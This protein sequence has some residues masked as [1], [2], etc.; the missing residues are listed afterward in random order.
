MQ[1]TDN[2]VPPCPL[3]RLDY[4]SFTTPPSPATRHFP[5]PQP[6]LPPTT[7]REVAG[8]AALTAA[9]A[10]LV[11]HTSD[12]QQQHNRPFALGRPPG[13]SAAAAGGCHDKGGEHADIGSDSDGEGERSVP[14]EELTAAPL[15]EALEVCGA[16]AEGVSQQR[17]CHDLMH[18]TAVQHVMRRAMLRR[19]G[20]L[21]RGL[22]CPG[23]SGPVVWQKGA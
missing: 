12:Q 10:G 18:C 16:G 14:V 2:I 20:A 11:Y 15:Q 9:Q 6:N 7:P 13:A 8:A 23:A 22:V 3:W 21:W 19:V 4:N 5:R 1:C 17:L